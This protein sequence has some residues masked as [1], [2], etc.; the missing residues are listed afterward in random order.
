M[1]KRTA[2]IVGSDSLLG[3][4][5]QQILS[6]EAPY[7]TVSLIG[8]ETENAILTER[9]G[10]PVV[11]STLDDASVA[12]ASVVFLTGTPE[13][14][15][16][17]LEIATKAPTQPALIDLTHSL[18]DQ[19]DSDLWAPLLCPAEIGELTSGVHQVAHP[20]AIVLAGFFGQLQQTAAVVRSVAQV[21]EPASEFGREGIDELQKQTTALLSFKELPQEVFDV[22]LCFNMAPYL[23]PAAQRRIEAT[24]ARICRHVQA[25]LP[26]LGKIPVP[27]IRVVQAPV[28][29]GHS[30]SVWAE[31][32]GPAD[33]STLIR[34]LASDQI[35]VRAASEAPPTNASIA[36]QNGMTVGRIEIDRS[37]PNAAWFWIVA[38]NH[39]VAASNAVCLATLLVPAEG[40]A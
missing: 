17:S 34:G 21:F 9:G 5:I 39:S 13:S 22:Q 12:A 38:D 35:E 24:E 33:L 10:E 7:I 29:H 6:E 3:N 37:N 14:C 20:A 19:P 23:G 32:E 25:L 4:E 8:D 40:R 11:L 2:A 1:A 30:F 27:S 26:K 31:F 18:E 28:F 15:Q 16:R 36:G